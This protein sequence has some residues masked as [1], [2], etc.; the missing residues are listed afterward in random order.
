MRTISLNPDYPC[1]VDK[2]LRNLVNLSRAKLI[3][4]P[5]NHRF[6]RTVFC[7]ILDYAMSSKRCIPFG[8]S[9]HKFI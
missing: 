9:D 8:V 7:Y 5:S 2:R 3:R 1:R 4:T 6:L